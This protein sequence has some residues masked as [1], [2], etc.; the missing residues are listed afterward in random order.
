MC[1][2]FYGF[3]FQGIQGNIKHTY[4]LISQDNFSTPLCTLKQISS[5]LSCKPPGDENAHKTTLAILNKLS[6]YSWDAKAVLTLAAFAIEYGEFWLLYQQNSTNNLLAES[7][8]KIKRV[9]ANQT[10][11]GA[12]KKHG[13]SILEVNKL[14]N[15]IL[16][17]I[18]LIFYFEKLASIHNTKDVPALIP[19]LEQITVHVYWTI[20]TVAAIVTQIDS[21]ILNKDTIQ[22]LAPYAQKIHIIFKKLT[23]QK[24]LIRAQIA[25]EEYL[26]TL[27]KSFHT[28]TEIFVTLKLLIAGE[29]A[30]KVL[31]NDG[32][33]NTKVGISVLEKKDVFLFFSTL[34]IT[35]SDFD[36]LIPIYNKFKLEDQY[37]ILWIPIVEEWNDELHI[38]F[39]NMKKNMSWYTLE[40]F[41]P[42][43]GKDNEWI[44]QFNTIVS[45]LGSDSTTLNE[46]YVSIELVHV[47]TENESGNRF[48]K[49]VESLFFTNI[50][51]TTNSV[52]QEVQK[53]FS[54]KNE[55]GWAILTHGSTVLVA[56]H[57]TT[58]LKTVS[59][60]DKWK[61]FVNEIEFE[62]SFKEYY[63]KVFPSTHSCTH[64]E[65]HKVT[66]A[67]PDFTECPE[68]H[69][70]MKVFVSYKCCHIQEEEN[71]VT[72]A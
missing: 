58:M 69:R 44:R 42:I 6:S 33:A 60:F 12:L 14:I 15:K 39:D 35:E 38:K 65:I 8:A 26:N 23:D 21:I 11:S 61:K 68:C 5:E 4:H 28:S 32:A 56:G 45:T 19:A 53:L 16:E 51:K 64:I 13:N 43:R 62:I 40:H 29:N 31:I 9:P 46:A 47:E 71:I 63:K 48:W 20:I 66:E 55:S 27:R 57:G 67:I 24:L 37:K 49:G 70:K 50:G 34:D 36:H 7:L 10:N 3:L 22:E 30:P 52:T 54:Y 59:E 25:E 2:F 1:L 17:V 18:E 41:E 72:N